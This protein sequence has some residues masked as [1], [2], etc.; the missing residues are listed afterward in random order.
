MK[1]RETKE[2]SREMWGWGG[3]EWRRMESK[4]T[5]LNSI[6]KDRSDFPEILVLCIRKQHLV[7]IKEAQIKAWSYF[8]NE[9]MR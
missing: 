7:L 8:M 5:Q 9:D 6:R 2:R 1:E 4:K 3:E